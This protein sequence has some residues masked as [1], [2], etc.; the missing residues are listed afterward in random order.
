VSRI[1]VSR[2]DRVRSEAK[3]RSRADYNLST[4]VLSPTDIN[5][6]IA[7]YLIDNPVG[8]DVGTVVGDIRTLYVDDV[9]G[10]YTNGT[11]EWFR[12]G[13]VDTDTASY[14]D[15]KINSTTFG[16]FVSSFITNTQ[17]PFSEGITGDGT[18][19][20]VLDSNSDTVFQ[21]LNGVYTGQSF[22]VTDN[23][24]RPE[25]LTFDGTHIWSVDVI[26]S[27]ASKYTTT[28]TYVGSFSAKTEA[29]FAL[30]ICWD[31]TH[32]WVI[33]DSGAYYQYD[34]AGVYTG[35]N[36]TT[37][38]A[39]PRDIAFTGEN[40]VVLYPSIVREYTTLG[41]STGRTLSVSSTYRCMDAVGMYL[42]FTRTST[43]DSA[44]QLASGVSFVG[45]TD[46]S[47]DTDTGLPI[48]VRVK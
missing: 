47:T 44:H 3:T 1:P 33:S 23:G 35:T 11:E 8:G 46:E 25:S 21:Y 36:Y 43:P 10:L 30:G 39:N 4:Q 18:F 6:I 17:A 12:S 29:L 28:G 37:G 2:K 19:V 26:T 20:Y 45:L 9:N 5:A 14:P 41:V 42:W 27:I 31:G 38:L 16:A 7:Q 24:N 32:F 40:F 22:L 34:A 13:V 48:Y 15:A